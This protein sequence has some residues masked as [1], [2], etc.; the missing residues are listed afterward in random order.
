[1]ELHRVLKP[2]GVLSM[3]DHHMKEAAIMSGITGGGLF[4]LL[5]KSK[6]V[7]NFTKI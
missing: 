4:R 7:Y 2:G 3:S 5:K 1:M 6:K